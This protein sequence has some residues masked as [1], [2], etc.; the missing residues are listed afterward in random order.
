MLSL[1]WFCEHRNW[2]IEWFIPSHTIEMEPEF[3]IVIP[4]G[5]TSISARVKS[6]LVLNCSYT[7]SCSVI[8][9]LAS[10]ILCYDYMI[11]AIHIILLS[12]SHVRLF[13]TPWTAARQASL[14]FSVSWSLLRLMST[15]LVMSQPSHIYICI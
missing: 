2:G 3:N 10:F 4:L 9:P 12:P 6:C 1:P 13:V 8:F 14:S 11:S 7:R 5:Y 15:E